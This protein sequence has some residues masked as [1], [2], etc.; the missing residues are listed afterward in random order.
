MTHD[1]TT[2]TRVFKRL[3]VGDWGR[4]Q[5]AEKGTASLGS[6]AFSAVPSVSCVWRTDG[7][8]GLLAGKPQVVYN[9]SEER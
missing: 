6:S 3:H 9:P 8:V 4:S 7:K 1:Q 2:A 5:V